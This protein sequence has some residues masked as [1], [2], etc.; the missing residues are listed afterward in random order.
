VPVAVRTTEPL[1]RDIE[2]MAARVRLLF[3]AG[4]LI[5][6]PDEKR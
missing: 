2:I 6:D 5:I 4:K 3:T 1:T